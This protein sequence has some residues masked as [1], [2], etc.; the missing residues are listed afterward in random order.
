MNI[1]ER[2]RYLRE[3]KNLSQGDLENRTGLKRCYISRVEHGHT[4]PSVENLQKIAHGLGMQLYQMLYDGDEV[5]PLAEA[6]AGRNPDWASR[7]PGRRFLD[8]LRLALSRMSDRDR[9]TLLFTARKMVSNRN[10]GA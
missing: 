2:V 4:V 10:G 7:G 9:D 5:A 8:R 3:V 1:A 6:S